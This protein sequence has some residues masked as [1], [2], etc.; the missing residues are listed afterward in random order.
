MND[1]EIEEKRKAQREYALKY[2]HKNKEENNIKRRILR[3]KRMGIDEEYIDHWVKNQNK[4]KK[5]IR[6]IEEGNIDLYLLNLITQKN[7]I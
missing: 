6:D 7:I 1:A 3:Y 5:L 2:Y 4:Y